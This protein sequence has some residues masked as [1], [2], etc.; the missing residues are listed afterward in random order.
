MNDERIYHIT[1]TR[2]YMAYWTGLSLDLWHIWY[3]PKGIPNS[4]AHGVDTSD[5]CPSYITLPYDQA[6]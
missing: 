2:Y 5:W 6:Y 3:Y 4:D 1:E